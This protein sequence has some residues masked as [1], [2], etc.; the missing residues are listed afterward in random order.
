MSPDGSSIV[1]TSCQHESEVPVSWGSDGS[2]RE[3]YIYEIATVAVDG[4]G[5][6]RLT[7][8]VDV[9]YFPAW[10]PDMTQIAFTTESGEFYWYM[11]QLAVMSTD[12][13]NQR[14]PLTIESVTHSPPVWSPDGRYIGFLAN[15]G[16]NWST[17]AL[18]IA[19][20]ESDDSGLRR[21]SEAESSMTW[22]PDGQR[23][24]FM[25]FETDGA[26]GGDER[27]RTLDLVTVAADGSDPRM[28]AKVGPV[29]LDLGG[30]FECYIMPVSWSPEG[31]HICT[32]VTLAC[33]SSTSTGTVLA[34]P[35]Q[36]GS[37]MK[38]IPGWPGLRM[39]RGLPYDSSI[40]WP[41]V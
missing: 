36:D 39:D 25:R 28:L 10:S 31:T 11:S 13:S 5:S 27:F 26:T 30:R 23:L 32:S 34:N 14:F 24:A 1:Y 38:T 2:G 17:S 3:K 40:I 7:E 9:D 41:A 12:G 35:R 16:E 33:A 22:S 15:E 6:E 19:I 21:I 29:P 8:N 20:V 18:Y 37:R 4:S